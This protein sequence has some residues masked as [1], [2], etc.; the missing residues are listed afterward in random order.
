MLSHLLSLSEIQYG[1]VIPVKIR[2]TL[3]IIIAAYISSCAS[4]ENGCLYMDA[5]YGFSLEYKNDY[6]IKYKPLTHF[7]SVKGDVKV[8]PCVVGIID[9]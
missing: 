6:G 3:T 7:M 4:A 5:K 1:D 2:N 9:V 8:A